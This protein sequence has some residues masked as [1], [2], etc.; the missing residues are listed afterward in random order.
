VAAVLREAA[1]AISARLG[2]APVMQ[3][4]RAA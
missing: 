3:R 2:H 1:H 4:G